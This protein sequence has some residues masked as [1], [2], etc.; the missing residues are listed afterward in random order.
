MEGDLGGRNEHW[1]VVM[2]LLELKKHDAGRKFGN[3]VDSDQ[4][5]QFGYCEI[6]SQCTLGPITE[7]SAL[8]HG[9]FSLKDRHSERLC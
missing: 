2:Q 9:L 3:V 1:K 4:L 7:V 5:T 6:Q 8:N